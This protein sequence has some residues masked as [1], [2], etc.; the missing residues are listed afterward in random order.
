MIW[1]NVNEESPP[2]PSPVDLGA[3]SY[4]Y[5]RCWTLDFLYMSVFLFHSPRL[6]GCF[7]AIQNKYVSQTFPKSQNIYLHKTAKKILI[8]MFPLYP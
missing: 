3:C 6:Q 5:K 1:L 8:C 7:E 4:L 2:T